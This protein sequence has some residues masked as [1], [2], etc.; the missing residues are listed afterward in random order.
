MTPDEYRAK[1]AMLDAQARD[2]GNIFSQA[3]LKRLAES[4]RLLAQQAE[5]N[6]HTDVV[7]E[8]QPLSGRSEAAQQQQQQQPQ[9]DNEDN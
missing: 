3:E 1:A 4:Y 9:P 6:T 7:Y 2:E 8:P 5:R